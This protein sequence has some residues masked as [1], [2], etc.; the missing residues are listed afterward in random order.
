M[1][2]TLT[3]VQHIIDRRADYVMRKLQLLTLVILELEITTIY[4]LLCACLI[5][6]DGQLNWDIDLIKY[7]F[8]CK[9]NPVRCVRWRQNT[10]A[11]HEIWSMIFQ[12]PFYEHL[13]VCFWD[14][15][16]NDY[17]ERRHYFWKQRNLICVRVMN[18]ELPQILRNC[19]MCTWYIVFLITI[20]LLYM[21]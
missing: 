19:A 12:F 5:N 10:E 18:V 7:L 2:I 8:C 16:A 21:Y 15:V 17:V 9:Y 14:W 4:P 3:K 13:N 6:T 11:P 20:L 1:S